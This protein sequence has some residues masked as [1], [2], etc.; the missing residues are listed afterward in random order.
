MKPEEYLTTEQV[1]KIYP[2]YTRETLKGMRYRNKSPFPFYKVG[3]TV[4]YKKSDIDNFIA[5]KKIID[6]AEE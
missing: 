3:R 4:R 5:S 2:F 6:I 1:A